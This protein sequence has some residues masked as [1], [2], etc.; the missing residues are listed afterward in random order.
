[1]PSFQTR[2]G[3]VT[4]FS[5]EIDRLFRA[6]PGV[7]KDREERH[8]AGAARLL[9]AHRLQECLGL[10]VV[11]HAASVDDARCPGQLPFQRPNRVPVDKPELGGVIHRVGKDDAMP[12][13]RTRRRVLAIHTSGRQIKH[14]AGDRRLGQRR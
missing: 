8:Q 11:D 5:R 9:D 10:A 7:I 12:P 6:K 4:S 3:K 14:P 2:D 1:M 13:G